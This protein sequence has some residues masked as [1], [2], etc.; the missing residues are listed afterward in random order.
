MCAKP[1]LTLSLFERLVSLKVG[2]TLE[3]RFAQEL[4]TVCSKYN[5]FTWL[6][7][8]SMP[9]RKLFG[10]FND[11]FPLWHLKTLRLSRYVYRFAVRCFVNYSGIF[12]VFCRSESQMITDFG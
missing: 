11:N 3:N 9:E 5:L 10:H 6:S 8:T 4:L 2:E 7:E 12:L 1:Y